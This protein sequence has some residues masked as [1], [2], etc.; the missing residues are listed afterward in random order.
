MMVAIVN[1][2]GRQALARSELIDIPRNV[3]YDHLHL[4]SLVAGEFRA[5]QGFVLGGFSLSRLIG[6][7][8][9]RQ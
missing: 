2:R 4:L 8:L 3:V 9:L 7:D 1:A 5:R 6:Y